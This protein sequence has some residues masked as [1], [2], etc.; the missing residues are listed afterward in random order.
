MKRLALAAAVIGS[1]VVSQTARASVNI[2]FTQTDT[3]VDVLATGSIDTATLAGPTSVAEVADGT[4]FIGSAGV[5]TLLPSS[6]TLLQITL[7]AYTFG[8]I[9]TG[10]RHLFTGSYISGIFGIETNGSYNDLLDLSPTYVSGAPI[11]AEAFFGGDTLA[12][13]GLTSGYELVEPLSNGDTITIS[14]A[15]P[16]PASLALLAAP[17]LGLA[18][19]RRR[20]G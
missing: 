3:G 11:V 16:E 19:L 12:G 5:V 18:G 17:L 13:F 6:P 15:V 1:L 4:A 7:P 8:Q 2:S 9:G 10:V 14:A 20:R